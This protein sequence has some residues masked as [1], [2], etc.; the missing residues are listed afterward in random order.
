MHLI[1]FCKI[2]EGDLKDSPL[3]EFLSVSDV[4]ML[5]ECSKT[6]HRVFNDKVFRR[7]VLLNMDDSLRENFWIM[8]CPFMEMQH[9]LRKRLHIGSVLTD[10]YSHVTECLAEEV[11]TLPV[12]TRMD[13]ALD[14]KRTAGTRSGTA[15]LEDSEENAAEKEQALT[16]ILSSFAYL[17]PEIGYH[18][19]LNSLAGALLNALT[20]EEL[21]FWLLVALYEQRGFKYVFG[22]G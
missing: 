2:F 17:F 18:T 21:A 4:L 13:I 7:C 3:P 15:S 14:A 20:D 9:E 19:G 5:R 6:L 11:E 16:S 12:K 8:Q 22:A 1:E 10:V